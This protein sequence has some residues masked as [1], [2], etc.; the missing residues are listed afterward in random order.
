MIVFTIEGRLPNHRDG[1]DL[2]CAVVCEDV[3][4]TLRDMDLIER[5]ITNA[6]PAADLDL[7]VWRVLVPST[8]RNAALA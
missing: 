5:A 2:G 4:R 1:L 8:D 7:V 6:D 3:S